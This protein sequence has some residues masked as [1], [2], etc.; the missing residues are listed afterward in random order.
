MSGAAAPR[1]RGNSS[2]EIFNRLLSM[3]SNFP[4]TIKL[5]LRAHHVLSDAI[6]SLEESGAAK[7]SVWTGTE[8]KEVPG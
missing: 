3:I 7:S 4:E 1:R 2:P 8:Y 5:G 6:L